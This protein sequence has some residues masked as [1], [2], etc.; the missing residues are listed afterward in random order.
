L[1]SFVCTTIA[2]TLAAFAFTTLRADTLTCDMSQYKSSSGPTATIDQNVLT[3]AWPGRSGSEMRARYAIDGGR[4]IVRDLA[5]RRG[6]GPWVTLGQNLTPEYHVVSGIRRMSTQQADPLKAAGVE[7]P[8][9]NLRYT[10]SSRGQKV[11]EVVQ[12]MAAEAG[13]DIKLISTE[14]ATQMKVQTDGDYQVVQIG[15]SGRPD[16]DGNIYSFY[17]CGGGLNDSHYCNPEVDKLLA[18][19]RLTTDV[20]ARKALYEKF[21]AIALDDLPIIYLYFEKWIWG[22]TAKLGGFIP[23]PDGMIRLEGMKLAQ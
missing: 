9:V 13:F 16:P 2:A 11:N 17:V 12:A 8:V 7:H 21:D 6:G 22:T 14:F 4:P 5:V 15:W 1:K 10:T 19:T 20:A 3:I 18:E 23:Y